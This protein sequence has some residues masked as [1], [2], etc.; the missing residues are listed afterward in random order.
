MTAKN[1]AIA[2]KTKIAL[3]ASRPFFALF[4]EMKIADIRPKWLILNSD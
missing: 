4:H 3:L 1:E 2:R